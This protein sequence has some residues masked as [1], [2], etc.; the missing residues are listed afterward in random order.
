MKNLFFF[1]LCFLFLSTN[2]QYTNRELI[3]NTTGNG[4]DKTTP[5]GIDTGKWSYIQKFANLTYNGQDAS[6]SAVR[7]YVDWTNYEPTPGDYQGRAK[8]VQ[9]IQTILNLKSGTMKIALHFPYQRPG[10]Q[11]GQSTDGYFDNSDL[12]K[13]SDGSYVRET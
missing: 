5:N 8:L 12:A 4:F 11:P 3:L 7:F 10:P 6:I 2:A 1:L 13:T 9:A